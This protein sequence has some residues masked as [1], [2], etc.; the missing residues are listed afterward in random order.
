MILN[1]KGKKCMKLDLYFSG[2]KHTE[3][4]SSHTIYEL[5]FVENNI[6][7]T[8]LQKKNYINFLSIKILLL[9]V[10]LGIQSIYLKP[11]I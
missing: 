2:C 9:E 6:F 7:I 5:F 1:V 10:I 4:N 11:L 3:S 8:F